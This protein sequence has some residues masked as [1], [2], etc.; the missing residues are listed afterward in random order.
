MESNSRA[1]IGTRYWTGEPGAA[2]AAAR[3]MHPRVYSYK[4]C[5]LAERHTQY[6]TAG[7]GPTEANYQNSRL[8]DIP[9]YYSISSMN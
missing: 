6:L 1:K 5:R 7:L 8:H 9:S 4:R 2:V 3:K